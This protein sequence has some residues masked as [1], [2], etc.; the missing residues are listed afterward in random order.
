M[1]LS[2]LD[3]RPFNK[4]VEMELE[5]DNL[6]NSFTA[7]DEPKEISEAWVTFAESCSKNLSAISNLAGMAV[8]RIYDVYQDMS[9][10][11]DN[12]LALH[13]LLYGDFPNQI[14]A[15]NKFELQLGVLTY[16]YSQVRNR[17]VFNHTPS[18][19]QYT[20]YILAKESI[21]R[22]VYRI[23]TDALPEV[24]ISGLT[25]TP[26]KNDLLDVIMPLVQL[27]NVK[28]LLPIYDNLPDSSTDPRVLAKKGE[29]DYL[30][31]VTLLTHI[32][33]ISRKT[34]QDFWWADPISELSILNHA[35]EH[36]EKVINLWNEAPE[37]VGNKGLAIKMDFIPIVDA[38][39]SVSMVQHFKLLAE[40]ALEGG[41][42]GHASRYYNKA[43]SEYKIACKILKK[44]ESSQSKS[45]LAEIQA[46]E[47]ELKILRTITDLALKYT[48]IVDKL[49]DQDNEGALASCMEIT[50]LLKQIEGAGSLPYIYGISVTYSSAASMINELLTQEH[51]NLNVIDRLI[52]Q[53]YFPL[54]AMGTALSEV[55]LSHVI[56][57]HDDPLISYN[58]FIELD[59]RLYYLEKAIEL[60]PQFISEKD[61]QRNKIHAL[62]YYVKSVIAEN[63]IYLFSDYNI[64][65]DLILRARAHYFAKKA[66]QS[67]SA[68]KKGEKELKNLINDRMIATKISGMV[69]ESSLISLG[70]QSAY[71]NNKR[72]LMK[73]IITLIYESDTL[74]EFIADSVEA[75]FKETTDFHGLL[76]LILLDTQELLAAN[77]NV[78]IKGNDINFD[79]VRRR[80]VFIPA[81]KTLTE[82]VECII[83]GELFA[84]NNKMTRAEGSYNRANKMFFEV[85][86]SMGKIMNYLEDQKELPQFLYQASLFCRENASSIRDRRKRQDP[87][88]S[89][90]ISALDYLVL[91]L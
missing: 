60:L 65:L 53:F 26:T 2:S 69:T 22:I 14:M 47:T 40:S 19:S 15:L 18:T 27:E 3:T 38:Q 9:K 68:F 56:V 61:Q 41:E 6:Y 77:V 25:P 20:Y 66:E 10:G 17:G 87:P 51:A 67:I 39:S 46:E 43:L 52:S 49:Y 79:F 84:K 70:L 72:T 1:H 82:A 80:E 59:E 58:E 71:K 31:G 35:K 36:F 64:V 37:S 50:E 29:Y 12:P 21:D 28:R 78:S 11:N 44:S 88:Y 63:K 73:E 7:L 13:E 90:I 62:R 4:F 33:D 24:E 48:E 89:D 74:P 34:S 54:K 32:I 76:D 45:L 8:E 85:S 16:V 86:E 81:I 83:L 30:Q 75:Q 23:L 91:K 57:N 42:L 55:P 5:R